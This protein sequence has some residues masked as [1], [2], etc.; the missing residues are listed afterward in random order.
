M[1][2]KLNLRLFDRFRQ[3]G[4]KMRSGH[5]P[6]TIYPENGDSKKMI[7]SIM[8]CRVAGPQR[9][10]ILGIL[11]KEGISKQQE[12]ADELH[13]SKSTL[14][15]MI[16]RLVDDGYVERTSDPSDRRTTVLVLTKT[17]DERAEEVI[18]ERIRVMEFM[19][20]N[21]T[22]EDKEE[23]IKLLDKMLGED[24]AVDCI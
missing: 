16:N 10:M 2:N 22:D 24:E 20:R 4:R 6:G 5:A 19:F 9:E 13:I 15:E 3:V 8:P 7:N 21:L 23:L 1:V 12:I 18:E 14:S 17:G 11:K